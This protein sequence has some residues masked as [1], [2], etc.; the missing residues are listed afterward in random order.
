MP[1]FHQLYNGDTFTLGKRERLKLACCDC[2]KV[3]QWKIRVTKQGYRVTVIPD[4]R[5]T[6]QTR[7][8][9]KKN[10]KPL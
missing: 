9:M 3:H 2:G 10:V 1:K 6:G 7:R 4:N 8:W 5:S